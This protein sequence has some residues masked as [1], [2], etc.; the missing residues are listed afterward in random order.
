VDAGEARLG[1]LARGQRPLGEQ[2]RCVAHSEIGG[3]GHGAI[4][5]RRPVRPSAD[6][7]FRM[8]TH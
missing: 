6:L 7:A 5:A 4:L 8:Q 1:Q 3:I 2:A